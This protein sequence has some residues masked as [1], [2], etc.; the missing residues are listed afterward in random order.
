M[1]DFKTSSHLHFPNI[2][3]F[4]KVRKMA[5]LIIFFTFMK[6][7]NRIKNRTL[8]ST[9]FFISLKTEEKYHSQNLKFP[10]QYQHSIPHFP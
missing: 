7:R 6:Y 5:L 3:Y 2:K 9:S 1:K 8:P 4:K 10:A